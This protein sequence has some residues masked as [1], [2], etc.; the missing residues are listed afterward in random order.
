MRRREAVRTAEDHALA[1]SRGFRVVSP[2]GR[3]GVVEEVL[4]RA[5]KGCPAALA[6]RVGLLGRRVE[7]VAAEDVAEVVAGARIL[8]VRAA[9]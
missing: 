8:R 2:H 3:I 4:Y 6:V 5:E 1:A 7:V 9:A